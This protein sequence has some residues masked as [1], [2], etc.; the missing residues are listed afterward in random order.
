MARTP[1]I[2]DVPKERKYEHS[3]IFL[4]SLAASCFEKYSGKKSFDNRQRYYL[5]DIFTISSQ[6]PSLH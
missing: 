5:M 4:C 6:K 1:S 2:Q 3:C